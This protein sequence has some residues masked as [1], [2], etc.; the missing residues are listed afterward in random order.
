[1]LHG[2]RRPQQ[3]KLLLHHYVRDEDLE[4][5]PQLLEAH[6]QEMHDLAGNKREGVRVA[7][8]HRHGAPTLCKVPNWCTQPRQRSFG[9]LSGVSIAFPSLSWIQAFR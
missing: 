4:W 8:P 7:D 6:L 1:M 3:P 5:D 9:A 2:V